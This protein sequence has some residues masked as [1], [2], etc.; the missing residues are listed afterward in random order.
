VGI[1]SGDENTETGV[2]MPKV[3]VPGVG[4]FK[5]SDE[6]T[7]A[8]IVSA[9][10]ELLERGRGP[11]LQL[12]NGEDFEWPGLGPEVPDKR[13]LE[14]PNPVPAT[15]SAEPDLA[16]HAAPEAIAE[17][18]PER[19]PPRVSR[20]QPFDSDDADM[21][22][23]HQLERAERGDSPDFPAPIPA[24]EP[25]GR[26]PPFG[27][28]YGLADTLDNPPPVDLPQPNAGEK[29][30]GPIHSSVLRRSMQRGPASFDSLG[31]KD[32]KR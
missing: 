1:R 9:I 5:F 23:I 24:L 8:E 4:I 6:M 14:T 30:G 19:R 28:K 32:Y 26:P 13:V 15:P 18:A 11:E 16:H 22:L 25:A 21:A 31:I 17:G 7:P 20:V 10:T 3:H 12:E 2:V 27:L 29:R